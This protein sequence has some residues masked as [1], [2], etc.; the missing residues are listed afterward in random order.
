MKRSTC[1]AVV[2]VL[3]GCAWASAQGLLN[4]LGPIPRGTIQAQVKPIASG[5]VSPDDLIAG[6]PGSNQLFVVDQAGLIRTIG[7][8]GLQSTPFLDLTT[9]MSQINNPTGPTG[10][11]AAYDERGLLGL[12]FSPGF[13]DPTSPGYRTFYTYQSEPIVGTADFGP[14]PGTVTSGID[15]QNVLSQWKMSSTNPNVVDLSSKR[16]LFREDHPA[17]NHNGGTIRFGPD[18]MLYLGIG[19]GG[20]ANDSGNGHEPTVGNAQNTNVI[21]GKILRINPLGNNSSN[22]KYGIPADNPFANGGGLK[23]IYAMG[24]RNPYR[25]SFDNPTGRLILGDVGQNNIEEVD[26]VIKGGNYGWAYKEGTFHFNRSD[27]SIDNNFSTIPPGLNLIDPLA[28]YD[29]EIGVTP[30]PNGIAIVGGYVYHGSLIPQLQGKYVFGD[31]TTSFGAADGHLFYADLTTGQIHSLLLPAPLG[32][33]VK[34]MGEDAN[35]ELYVMGST[36]LGPAGN[37]GVVLEIV[38]EPAAIAMLAPL[39]LV[40]WRNRR[41][42]N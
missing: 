21:M 35:G 9:L 28:E 27:G 39:A 29:H 38:P 17:L 41:A 22:G 36:N 18:G 34:G 5:L 15:H 16:D 10:L 37:N 40:F 11:K 3:C 20:T 2:T 7:S 24:V 30:N 33:Y 14:L 8:G 42:L 4:P 13:N 19:D 26:N 25:F 32:I 31:F 23:E 1:S 6:P 12:A